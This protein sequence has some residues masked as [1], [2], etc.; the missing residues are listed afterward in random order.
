MLKK[1][2]MARL[3]KGKW[4]LRRMKSEAGVV[5]EGLKWATS[6]LREEEESGGVGRRDP[7]RLQ[8]LLP[9]PLPLH[10]LP[11]FHPGHADIPLSIP[12][13]SFGLFHLDTS[14][15]FIPI[16]YSSSTHLPPETSESEKN[17]F[18]WLMRLLLHND[19]LIS[20]LTPAL[21]EEKIC[22]AHTV[23]RNPVRILSVFRLF[24]ASVYPGGAGRGKPTQQVSLTECE[25]PWHE[26]DLVSL[27]SSRRGNIAGLSTP[28]FSSVKFGYC[29]YCIIAGDVILCR[30]R[31]PLVSVTLLSLGEYFPRCKGVFIYFS[32]PFSL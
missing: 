5:R 15:I 9:L 3:D 29:G 30:E 13:F 2:H 23:E 8:H 20:S 1:G 10:F 18:L 21:L 25:F 12:R 19:V 26:A 24:V 22:P 31:R 16:P 17:Q 28:L 27:R 14:C 4:K 11:S 7:S 6:I 32:T